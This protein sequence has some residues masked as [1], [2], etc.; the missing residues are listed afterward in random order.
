VKTKAKRV[1]TTSRRRKQP[2]VR[3][4]PK[5]P[6]GPKKQQI[7]A[8][9]KGREKVLT[10][11]ETD[12]VRAKYAKGA[13]DEEFYHFMFVLRKHWLDPTT[14]Q[15][16]CVIFEGERTG[17]NMVIIIG[18][19]GYRAM[20]ARSH[21]KDFGGTSNGNWT[22]NDSTLGKTP[23][24]KRIPDTATVHAYRKGDTKDNPS[25]SAT[26]FWEEFA[27]A[28]LSAT[29]SDFWNRMPKHMLAK[30]AEAQALRKAFPD[31]TTIYSTE[32][33][34]QR[35]QDHTPGGR[36]IVHAG[37]VQP[38]GHI[39]S[40]RVQAQQNAKLIAEAKAKGNW[41]EQHHCVKSACPADEHTVEE[42]NQA[43]AE[44]QQK[45]K[46]IDVKPESVKAS[47]PKEHSMRG[48]EFVRGTLH[49]VMYG[50]TKEKAVP[51][52]N[53]RINNVW[54]TIWSRTLHAFFPSEAEVVARVIEC[55]VDPK[56][57]NVVGL[58]RLG[59]LHFAEDGRTVIHR[60][61]GEDDD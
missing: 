12:V 10:K 40:D 5:L 6:T 8:I 15:A 37:G 17:R 35:L 28:N 1:A 25:G 32:E 38:S 34:S 2:K 24:G 19:G 16:Y 21:R 55:Y 43:F 41:C 11:E 47:K 58:N 54:H 33:M 46:P 48:L 13:T 59:A 30:C 20:A 52:I 26:V 44:S 42:N 56:N 18:I 60:E 9:I 45:R 49:S 23:A 50:K 51:Y 7:T 14:N 22:F 53:I 3:R 31:L 4:G 61:P 57:K 36:E 39:F 27:P 29:R